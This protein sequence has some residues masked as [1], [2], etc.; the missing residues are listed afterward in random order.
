MEL[1]EKKLNTFL[2]KVLNDIYE[3]NTFL[4]NTNSKTKKT[5]QIISSDLKTA[6]NLDF[7]IFDTNTDDIID[8]MSKI[9]E[10]VEDEKDFESILLIN[11]VDSSAEISNFIDIANEK[12]KLEVDFWDVETINSYLK[13]YER[14]LFEKKIAVKKLPFLITDTQNSKN[15]ESS[16][17]TATYLRNGIGRW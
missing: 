14:F 15:V 1:N 11:Y 12:T 9:I 8:N 16:I 4:E 17:F 2:I 13:T 7:D 3:T 10:D 6:V 5:F